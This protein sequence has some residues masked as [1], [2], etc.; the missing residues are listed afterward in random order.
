MVTETQR[1]LFILCQNFR[2]GV[3]LINVLLKP[4]MK[5]NVQIQNGVWRSQT[6][7]PYSEAKEIEIYRPQD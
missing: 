3:D 6:I 1:S 2:W 4:Q 5:V 7:Y